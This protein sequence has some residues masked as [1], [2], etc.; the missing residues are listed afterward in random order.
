MNNKNNTCFFS[1]HRTLS[2]G[3]KDRI[4]F[5]LCEK[6]MELYN[7]GITDYITGGALGFD[8]MASDAIIKLKDLHKLNGKMRLLMYLPCR[9][10]DKFWKSDERMHYSDIRAYA[11]KIVLVSEKT[12]RSGCMSARNQRM[13]NDSSCGIVYKVFRNS[14]TG[15]TV[16]MA[17]KQGLKIFNICDLI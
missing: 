11:D 7:S 5:L 4:E 14:G 15:Q 3:D 2:L 17:E 13:V 9:D 12:Y 16:A 8:M 6:I 10:Y 1:G